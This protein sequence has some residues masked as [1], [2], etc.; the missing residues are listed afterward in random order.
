MKINVLVKPNSKQE[1][2]VK[3]DDGS[4]T[5]RANCPPIEGRANVRVQELLADYFDIPK[6]KIS[7]VSG[8][9]GKKKIFEIA[10]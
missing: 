8:L 2:V 10:V 5:V 3:N 7:I 1:S 6:S 9:K 4:Y